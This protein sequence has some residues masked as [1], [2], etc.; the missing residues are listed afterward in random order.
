MVLLPGNRP[1]PAHLPEQPL[2]HLEAAAQILWQELAG[3]LAGIDED[4]ARFEHADR[5][6]AARRFVVDHGGHAIVRRD[7][8]EIRLELLA[9]ADIDAVKLVRQPCLLEEQGDLM[10]VGGR[11]IIELDHISSPSAARAPLRTGHYG[12]RRYGPQAH[13]PAS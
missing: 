4:G 13:R 11:P 3:L 5:R 7:L 2:Q 10:P 9:L 1:E 12:R 6:P 8:E